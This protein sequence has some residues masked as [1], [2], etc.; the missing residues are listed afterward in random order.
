MVMA[1]T[2]V[3]T[4]FTYIIGVKLPE[5]SVCT[6][7]SLVQYT[8]VSANFFRTCLNPYIQLYKQSPQNSSRQ[9]TEVSI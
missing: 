4:I 5:E 9:S 3:F 2:N 8:T 6:I 7:K 1:D